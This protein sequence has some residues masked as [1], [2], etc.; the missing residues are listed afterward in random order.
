MIDYTFSYDDLEFF[1]L[2]FVRISC[3]VVTAP[4]FS[5]QNVPRRVKAGF[6]FVLAYIVYSTMEVHVVPQY[7]T[8]YG[9]AVL[10]LKEAIAG[11]V[12]GFGANICNS[13]INL[14]GRLAD[15]EIGIS[16]V[17]LFDP[18]TRE[19]SGFTGVLYQYSIMLIMMVTNL[20]HYFIRALVETFEIIP[21]GMAKFES[22][23]IVSIIIRYLD[24]YVM[25]AFR[26]CLPVV[27]TIMLTNAVLG[28]LVK[29]APQINMFSV[30]IQ[31]K[32]L[33][34]LSTLMITIGVLPAAS[35]FIFDEM[36]VI[37]TDMIRSMT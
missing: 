29:S 4:F 14:A 13:V 26:I 25:I 34:G 6:S 23:K 1:L 15:M 24:D 11:L 36:K 20:H 33:I 22:D 7:N 18:T 17:S 37:M 31:I 28:I 2:I 27:A 19:Q 30:G 32:L 21:I 3:F 5:I 12:I 10:V 8:V 35:D 16:M 9:Y